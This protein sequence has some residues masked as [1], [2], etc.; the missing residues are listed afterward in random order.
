MNLDIPQEH[1]D[2]ILGG[3]VEKIFNLK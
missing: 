3:N 1:K 2:M